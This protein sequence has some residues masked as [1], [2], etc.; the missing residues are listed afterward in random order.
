MFRS[1]PMTQMPLGELVAR[2]NRIFCDGTP[3][4]HY[5]TL[6]SGSVTLDGDVE[7]N[8]AGHP[9]PFILG[10]DGVRPIP[11]MTTPIGL[12]CQNDFPTTRFTLQRGE[13]L[14]VYTDGLTEATNGSGEQ[15]GEK[16]LADVLLHQARSSPLKILEACVSDLKAFTGTTTKSDDRTILVLQRA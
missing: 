6:V 14:V 3:A 4:G 8:N 2:A 7:L 11:S 15:Y 16:R 12:F 5:A 10:R 9:S 13:S 1:L